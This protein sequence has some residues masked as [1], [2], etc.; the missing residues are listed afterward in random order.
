[1]VNY[2]HVPVLCQEAIDLLDIKSNSV[3]VDMTLGRAGHSSKML[4]MIPDGY[5]Y[6]TDKDIQA[7]DYSYGRLSQI[8]AN[9]RLYNL[10]FSSF[11]DELKKDGVTSADCILLDIGVSS[12]QFDDP[13]RGFSYRYDAPLDMRMNQTQE[14]TA[15]FVVNNYSEKELKHIIATYGEDPFA[16]RIAHSIITKRAIKPIET[17]FELVEAIKEALPSYVLS[18]KGHP[19]KQTFQAIRYEVNSEINELKVG[20]QKGLEFLSVGGRLAI[21]TFNSLEDKIVKDMFKSYTSYVPENRNLPP[22]INKPILK[23]SLVNRKPIA[24][25]KSELVSNPRSESAKLRVI[26]RR[27]N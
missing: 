11:V 21:I 15:K 12:P 16:N 22:I 9:F 24:P 27:F 4:E 2:Q 10:P 26:E 1:M 13:L 6:A 23:Y 8:R 14:L 19:A 25:S 5:L 7:L 17:T 18:K 20:L 3:C